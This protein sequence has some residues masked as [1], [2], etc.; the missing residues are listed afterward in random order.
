LLMLEELLCLG[1]PNSGTAWAMVRP[2]EL[3]K[4][5]APEKTSMNILREKVGLSKP[6]PEEKEK[7]AT[8]VPSPSVPEKKTPASPGPSI[9]E[10]KVPPP[11][12]EEKEKIATPVPSPSVPEK[13]IPTSAGSS[14]ADE[15]VHVLSEP[16]LPSIQNDKKIIVEAAPLP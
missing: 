6:E 13:K 4:L 1:S 15:R 5:E 12:P 8:P 9:A 3:Q 14:I 11:E 10:K 2:K 16:S 7:I